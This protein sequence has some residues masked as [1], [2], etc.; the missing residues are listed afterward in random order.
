VLLREKLTVDIGSQLK[1]AKPSSL[2][3][4]FH[5]FGQPLIDTDEDSDVG[6]LHHTWLQPNEKSQRRRADGLGKQMG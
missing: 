2:E 5:H 6:R 4:H 1:V 3:K